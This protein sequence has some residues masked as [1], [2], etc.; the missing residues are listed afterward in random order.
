M[1]S[2]NQPF[3]GKKNKGCALNVNILIINKYPLLPLAMSVNQENS[4]TKVW[5][6]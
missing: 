2:F 6:Y 3:P 1:E 4:M 5:T